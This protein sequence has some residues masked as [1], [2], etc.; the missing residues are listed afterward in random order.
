MASNQL[1]LKGFNLLEV[2][3]HGQLRAAGMTGVFD[4]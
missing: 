2:S 4:I 1:I 3:A